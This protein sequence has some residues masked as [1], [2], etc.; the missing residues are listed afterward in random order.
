MARI[1]SGLGWSC[2]SEY[3][4]YDAETYLGFVNNRTWYKKYDGSAICVLAKENSF[5]HMTVISTVLDNVTCRIQGYGDTV[6]GG[7]PYTI[8]G[9]DWYI[10]NGTGHS[11]PSSYGSDFPEVNLSNLSTEQKITRILE[12]AGVIIGGYSNNTCPIQRSARHVRHHGVHKLIGT[13]SER[14]WRR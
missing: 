13:T 5:R 8:N 10:R 7:G 11:N 4:V 9:V 14:R 1:D 2:K 12:E 6:I 3:Y